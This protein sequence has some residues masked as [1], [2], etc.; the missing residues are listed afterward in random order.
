MKEPPAAAARARQEI[1]RDYLTFYGTKWLEGKLWICNEAALKA[2]GKR[3]LEAGARSCEAFS[4]FN[5]YSIAENCFEGNREIQRGDLVQKLIQAFEFLELICVNLFL[6][7]WRKE[8]KSLKT[9]TGNFVYS[10]QSVLPANTVEAI[11]EKIGYVATTEMEFSLVGKI[12]EEETKQIEFEIFLAR[13]ECETILEMA[14]EGRASDF[15]A[16]LQKRA[17]MLWHQED[18][19]RKSLPSQK[20][21]SRDVENCESNETPGYLDAQQKPLANNEPSFKMAGNDQI[22]GESHCK[23]AAE[24]PW[25]EF[26]ESASKPQEAQMQAS[27]LTCFPSKSSDSEDFLT[28]YSDIFIGQKRIFSQADT[29]LSVSKTGSAPLSPSSSGPQALAIFDDVTLEVPEN[30]QGQ[31]FPEDTIEAKIQD[32]M[33]CT[34][35]PGPNPRD[36]PGELKGEALPHG[37]RLRSESDLSGEEEVCELSSS[38]QK[39]KIKEASVEELLYSAEEVAQ[40]KSPSAVKSSD[41]DNR[42]DCSR[43]KCVYPPCAPTPNTEALSA[44]PL[45]NVVGGNKGPTINSDNGRLSTDTPGTYGASECFRHIREPPN[46]TYIPPTSIDVQP[47]GVSNAMIQCRWSHFPPDEGS[48]DSPVHKAKL[49]PNTFKSNKT[50]QESYVVVSKDD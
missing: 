26:A 1:I 33:S 19:D 17:Q 2:K 27:D 24:E 10:V 15:V 13:I 48:P 32:A 46:S 12:N 49:E 47:H 6:S 14:N 38:F 9:F 41:A 30:L 8:I 5:L 20:E 7:P 36:Q 42:C 16:L 44:N 43:L 50:H 28:R 34:S 39:L 29:R 23:P 31:E 11:L 25:S 18:E 45:C 37:N 21:E 40:P 3:F 22:K 4:R 35:M